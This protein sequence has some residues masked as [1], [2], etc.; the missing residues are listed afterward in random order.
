MGSAFFIEIMLLSHCYQYIFAE[1]YFRQT[2]LNSLLL[3]NRQEDH[4]LFTANPSKDD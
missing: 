3:F 4:L 2:S 1:E